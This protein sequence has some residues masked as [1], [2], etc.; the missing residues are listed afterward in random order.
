MIRYLGW[1]LLHALITIVVAVSLVFIAVR[2]LP[3]NPLLARFGQ[4][5]DLKQIEQLREQYGWDQPLHVQLGQFFWQVIT[6][7]DL[8]NSLARSH[9]S[10]NR[11][12]R[13]RIPATVELTLA[14]CSLAFPLGVIAGVAAAVWKNRWPDWL[15]TAGSLVGVSVPVFFLGILLRLIFSG[16]PTSQRL[17]AD[18]FDFDPITGLF[19]IDTLLRG[20]PDLWLATLEH[21]I[22]PAMAL[23]TIPAAI[24]AR[25]TRA[26]M[27]DVLAADYLRTARAKG[28]SLWRA[29]W[30]HALPNAA[31]P[32]V[33]IAGLQ[34]GLLLS[35]AVL[36]ETV[37]DWP[38]MG[39]YIASAVLGDKD[40]VAVQAGAIVICILFVS[41]NL[42][43]DLVFVWLDPRIRLAND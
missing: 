16:L 7:G 43:L 6:T 15:C 13:Q 36:T 29:V 30:R 17:P 24:V 21:L 38:G 28:C 2:L 37:F 19:L 27:L 22:L 9:V 35:G 42:L 23:A 20:R 31:V 25:I 33:N 10:V 11:E 26:A 40:Y 8:G 1:R 34:V 5:P 3:G 32:V 12:L 39:T 18:V 4:H 41:M 14:A